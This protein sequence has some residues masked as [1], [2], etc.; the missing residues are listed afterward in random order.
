MKLDP[1]KTAVLTL[2][3]QQGILSMVKGSED[4]IP[5]AAQFT[6]FSR[7]NHFTL[8]HVG[9]GFMAGHPEIPDFDSPFLRMKQNNRFVLGTPTA[10]FE[11]TI[12]QP[13]DLRIYKQRYSAFSQNHLSLVLRARSID[14]LVFFGVS[15]SG[16]VLS[17]IR[18]A[19]DLDFRCVIVKDLCLDSDPEIHRVLTEKVFPRQATVLT[20]EEFKVANS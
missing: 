1:K 12:V 19:F 16:I 8:I 17:T 10:E 7:R 18:N 4:L 9:L 6:E 5:K 2:D 13:A 3:F 20:V 15:T 14:H 11:P